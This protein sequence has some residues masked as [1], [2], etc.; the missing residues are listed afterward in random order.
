MGLQNL[1]FNL[2]RRSHI[3]W[4]SKFKAIVESENSAEQF[5]GSNCM[6]GDWIL[7]HIKRNDVDTADLHQLDDTH[8]EFHSL[9]EEIILLFRAKNREEVNKKIIEMEKCCMHVVLILNRLEKR[10]HV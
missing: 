5:P 2:V 8:Q 6:L 1:D 10:S 9:S 7:T 3:K 4:M